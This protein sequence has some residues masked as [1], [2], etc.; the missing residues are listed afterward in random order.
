VC[1]EDQKNREQ[2]HGDIFRAMHLVW[3]ASLSD[4]LSM[5]IGS[6]KGMPIRLEI[7]TSES[8]IITAFALTE[9]TGRP[10]L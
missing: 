4:V 5:I 1:L 9:A 7:G 8:L 2:L 6:S 10:R 3:R